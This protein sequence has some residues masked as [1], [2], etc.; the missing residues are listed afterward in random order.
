[1]FSK[2]IKFEVILISAAILFMLFVGV[3]L[4]GE[5]PS[6]DAGT[7]SVPAVTSGTL[8]GVISAINKDYVV[9]TYKSE[10]EREYEVLLP[11]DNKKTKVERKKDI[12]ALNIGDTVSIEYEDAQED[13]SVGKKVR[14]KAK[15]ISFVRPAPPKPPEP[16]INW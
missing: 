6:E 3:V 7:A 5:V 4:A 13:T 10:K 14:R 12:S 11:I 9:I 15:V 8:E 16:E 2:L 1:M